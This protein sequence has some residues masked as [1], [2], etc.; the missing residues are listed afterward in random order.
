MGALIETYRLRWC[1]LRDEFLNLLFPAHCVG[2]RRLGSWYCDDCLRGVTFVEP[3]LC[4][5]C[6][7]PG[8]SAGVCARCRTS[9]PGIDHIR[10]VAYFDGV[11]RRAI[12]KLKYQGCTVLA[13]PLGGLLAEYWVRQSE[14]PTPDLVV[15]VA[16]HASRLRERGYNQAALL[17]R[18]LADHVGADVDE[19]SLVRRRATIP[20]TELGG[21]QRRENVRDAFRCVGENLVGKRVLLVDDVCTT[22]ATLEACAAALYAGGATTVDALT[23]ARAR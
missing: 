1:G 17:A 7:K 13:E 2:C 6:G 11:L 20:Q 4:V 15:P 21:D 19:T 8:I 22:G 12:H 14:F 3:L 18:R 16:L 9:P 23:L 5:R 10:S